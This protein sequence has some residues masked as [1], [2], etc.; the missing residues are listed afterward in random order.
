[1]GHLQFVVG[2]GV[3]VVKIRDRAGQVGV[4][5][6]VHIHGGEVDQLVQPLLFQLLAPQNRGDAL[7]AL[8]QKVSQQQ[9][10][11]EDFGPV[12]VGFFLG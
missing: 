5:Q 10:G 1:M 9:V 4:G 12:F 7:P 11:V 2:G 8:L 3:E 6:V